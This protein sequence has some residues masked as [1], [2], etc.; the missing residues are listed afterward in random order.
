MKKLYWEPL[1]WGMGLIVYLLFFS[2]AWSGANYSLPPLGSFFS[3][4]EGFW[5]NADPVQS[6][7]AEELNLPVSEQV[8]I[9]YD[10]HA[11]PHIFANN[12]SDAL[13]ALGYLHASDR[14]FQMDFTSR[15]AS[16]Q[17]AEI[18]GEQ[19]LDYDL[20]MRKK[21][22][23]VMIENIASKWQGDAEVQNH[24]NPYLEGAN[25]YIQSMS[26]RNIPIEFKLI[27]YNPTP[28]TK[29]KIASIIAYLN[30]ELTFRHQDIQASLTRDK[31]GRDDFEIL[32]PQRHDDIP[33]VIPNGW[34][35]ENFE[36]RTDINQDIGM[37]E[38]F[39]SGQEPWSFSGNDLFSLPNLL[40]GSNNWAVGPGKTKDGSTIVSNDTHL[41]LTLP[42]I[43]Y[44][45]H[46][47]TPDHNF[48]GYSIPGIPAIFIGMTETIALA[49]TN[50]GCDYVD[51]YRIQWT[52]REYESYTVDGERK[53]VQWRVEDIHIRNKPTHSDSIPYTVFG[54]AP[55]TQN[56]EHPLRDFAMHWLAR[57]PKGDL[58]KSLTQILETRDFDQFIEISKY[59]S[60]PPQN[61]VYGDHS[62][63]IGLRIT[64]SLPVRKDK[65][66]GK[67]LKDGSTYDSL[68]N[69]S[70]PFEE[71]PTTFNPSSGFVAS[72]NQISTGT[73]YPYFNVGTYSLDRGTYLYNALEKMENIG[74][75][76]MKNLQT[77]PTS[78]KAIEMLE[79]L[80]PLLNTDQLSEK[81]LDLRNQLLKWDCRFTH[82]SMLSVL[83]KKWEK[84]FLTLT[85]DEFQNS[86]STHRFN[87]LLKPNWKTTIH[88]TRSKPDNPYFNIVATEQKESV[89]DIVVLSYKNAVDSYLKWE[90]EHPD[91][92]WAHYRGSSIPHLTRID[93][94]GLPLLEGNGTGSA[95]NSIKETHGPSMRMIAQFTDEERLFYSAL[96]GGTSGNPGSK[97]Y[98]HRLDDYQNGQYLKTYVGNSPDPLYE[99]A[100]RTITINPD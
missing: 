40:N 63:N 58:M 22:M 52:N 18:L 33:P 20:E 24:L 11:I 98:D 83:F 61:L 84:E 13:Y 7:S 37:S 3:P 29:E 85:W 66:D 47:V 25:Q 95:L 64:G 50:V 99:K 12:L 68:F 75:E 36:T 69:Q 87:K 42:S 91:K 76:E 97:Y 57:E 19:A 65:A 100:V 6:P 48:Y 70:I 9:I 39:H 28:W 67:F 32:F 43:W 49:T 54:P 53:E 16:G 46:I 86:D 96:P 44:E 51:W 34:F 21:G 77:D 45:C 73:D 17:I 8:E 35:T 88:L 26:K 82:N 72:A 62:G 38:E 31:I 41:P 55:F 78:Q 5:Q 14:L 80:L 89:V 15:A 23:S 79:V 10:Q 60:D 90:E 81:E 56:E 2:I 74:I 4:S 27:D 1:L 59:L 30:H 92:K 71:L 94:F 93:A